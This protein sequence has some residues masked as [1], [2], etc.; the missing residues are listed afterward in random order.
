MDQQRMLKHVLK[1]FPEPD[2]G[3]SLEEFK[4]YALWR[5]MSV[6]ASGLHWD[7]E[8]E[9]QTRERIANGIH[10]GRMVRKFT[11][12]SPGEIARGGIARLPDDDLPI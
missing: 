9:D 5:L 12:K 3:G 10:E 11:G 6:W 1:N 7:E 2:P 8:P 4:R